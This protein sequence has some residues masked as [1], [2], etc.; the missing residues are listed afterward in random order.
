MHNVIVPLSELPAGD[1]HF[2]RLVSDGLNAD[3]LFDMSEG[4][5]QF[6]AGFRFAHVRA[7][8]FCQ[9]TECTAFQVEAYGQL[10]EVRP[11]D[12]TSE[13]EERLA[14]NGRAPGEWD[15]HHYLIYVPNVGGAYEFAALQWSQLLK[16]A[17]PF[18]P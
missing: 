10:V 5:E 16:H 12:W 13:L 15:T 1:V 8:R 14:V 11:S 9:E 18:I 3:L 2:A 4:G 6:H 7:M 17:G